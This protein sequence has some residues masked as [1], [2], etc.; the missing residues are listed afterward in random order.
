MFRKLWEKIL[1]CV[2]LVSFVL[3]VD[4][5][6]IDFVC[7]DEINEWRLRILW[8]IVGMNEWF[9]CVKYE[10]EV[11]FIVDIL[12]FWYFLNVKICLIIVWGGEWII[13][14]LYYNNDY[15]D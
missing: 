14:N 12:I 8:V 9:V 15:K 3:M 1:G 10:I 6:L 11:M 4:F 5:W 13:V 7:I 2:V